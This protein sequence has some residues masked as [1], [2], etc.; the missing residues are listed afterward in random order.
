MAG[1]PCLASSV[2]HRRNTTETKGND[3]TKEEIEKRDT[4][5]VDRFIREVCRGTNDY[6][7]AVQFIAKK[8]FFDGKKLKDTVTYIKGLKQ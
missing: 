1:N 5:P 6:S 8:W 4:W 2:F 3:M 7:G